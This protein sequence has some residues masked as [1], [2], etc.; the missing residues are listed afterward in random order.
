M[1]AAL[2]FR[3][4]VF[5]A[6]YPVAMS[7]AVSL[8]FGLSLFRQKTLCEEIAEKVPPHILPEGASQ[9]CRRLTAFWCAVLAANGLVAT[10]TVFG[11][12]WTWFAWNCALSYAA[13]W[14][15]AGIEY[16]LRRRRF[17]A[18]FHTSG[19]TAKPKT[20]V[21]A[22]ST[23]AK[24]VAFHLSRLRAEG[25]LPQKGGKGPI[26]LSTVEPDHMYGLLWR[27]MLPRAAGCEVDDEVIRAP[28]SLLAKMHSAEKVVLVTTPSF[29]ERFTAYA[30]QY[31]VPQNCVEIVSSGALL[32]EKVAAATKRVFGRAPREIFG[33]TETGGVAWRRQFI[34]ATPEAFDWTPLD[35]VKTSISSD[36]RLVVSSPFSCARRYTMGDGVE[37]SPDGRRFKLLGRLDRLVKINEQRVSLPEME[38]KMSALPMISEAALAAIDGPHGTVLGAVVV[39]APGV[40]FPGKRAFARS[41]RTRLM[42]MFPL[43]TAPRKFRFVYE[44][45]R[46]AQGKVRAEE[47]RRILASDF[48]E[49]LVQN[50]AVTADSWSADFTFD[51]DSFY[52]QGHF[53][54]HPILP[55]VVQLGMA[56]HFAEIFAHRPLRLKTAK[57]LKFMQVVRPEERIRFSLERKSSSEYVF[58]YTRGDA[59]CSTGVLAVEE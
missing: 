47:L 18:V 1:A 49:P 56:H 46:N 26:F 10:A 23:L 52:F 14:S 37:F 39:L 51:A 48:A 38:A 8:G 9:Y 24:E 41:L 30:D 57:K 44:L 3:R 54:D 27:K 16:L 12:R 35:P 34:T 42:Q 43:A 31:D 25:V 40:D 17:A 20:I 36:G 7:A 22:F 5:V 55:G 58:K 29:L 21:K 4:F 11:P 32:T 19:S 45:P 33:S 59:A 2:I 50:V 6:W 53:P 15:I 13:I 28:E